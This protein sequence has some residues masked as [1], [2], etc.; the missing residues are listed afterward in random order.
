[1]CGEMLRNVQITGVGVKEG[2]DTIYELRIHDKRS[3]EEQDEFWRLKTR[4]EWTED[5]TT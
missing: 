2:Q 5:E 1:M 3:T 4:S